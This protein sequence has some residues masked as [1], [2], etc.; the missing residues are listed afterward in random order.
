MIAKVDGSVGRIPPTRCSKRRPAAKAPKIPTAMPTTIQVP[1][2][3]ELLLFY[4]LHRANAV[5][6]DR[7]VASVFKAFF[8]DEAWVFLKN[9]ASWKEMREHCRYVRE[10]A[11]TYAYNLSE[12]KTML[13]ALK[14]PAWTVLLTAAFTGLRKAE[15]RGLHWEDFDG[16]QLSVRRSVWNSVVSEPKS[17]H[18]KALFRW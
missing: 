6:R 1:E 4:I 13:A 14:E 16:K 8:I 2:L 10:A 5:I 3:L 7:A 15:I 12:I 9:P 18:S 11:D 17:V